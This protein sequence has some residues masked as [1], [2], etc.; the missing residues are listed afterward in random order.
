[1]V[2]RNGKA[3]GRTLVTGAGALGVRAPRV[4]DKREG[5]RFTSSILPKYARRSPK[6]ADVLPVLYLRGLST[7]ERRPVVLH[8]HCRGPSRRHERAVGVCGRV[9]GVDRFVG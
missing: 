9:P 5:H 6:V 3:K 4:H 8:G 2:V 1:M 7:G